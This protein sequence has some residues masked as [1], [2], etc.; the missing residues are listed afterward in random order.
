LESHEART[1]V[2]VLV[3]EG[4]W[5]SRFDGMRGTVEH[6]WGHDDYPALDVR[7]EDG[8]SELFWFHELERPDPGSVPYYDGS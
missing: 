3:K 6:V 2:A 1:G 8:R 4:H 5:K 7:F